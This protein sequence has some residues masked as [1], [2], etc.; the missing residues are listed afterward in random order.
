MGEIN[1]L[2]LY[3]RSKRNIAQREEAVPR[4]GTSGAGC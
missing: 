2:D 3:P 1:L 4:G